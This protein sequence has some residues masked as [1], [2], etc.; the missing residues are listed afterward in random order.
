MLE[1]SISTHLT[2]L[3]SLG[4]IGVVFSNEAL[5]SVCGEQ[6]RFMISHD[7]SVCAIVF[8]FRKLSYVPMNL[9]LFYT[10]SSIRFNVS[11]F[12]SRSLILWT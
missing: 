4:Y 10:F 9:R 12:M 7:L 5:L 6:L 3:C 1:E 8:L 2:S 11:D